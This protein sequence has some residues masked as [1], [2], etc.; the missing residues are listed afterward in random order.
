[1]SLKNHKLCN[2][3]QVRHNEVAG[4]EAEH[5]ADCGHLE[6]LDLSHNRL[7]MLAGR[8]TAALSIFVTINLHANITVTITALLPK[9]PSPPPPGSVDCST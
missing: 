4:L 7:A 8:C 9:L 3:C 5:L 6:H 2:H 1:M